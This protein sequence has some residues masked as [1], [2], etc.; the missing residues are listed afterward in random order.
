MISVN[1]HNA[2]N[3]RVHDAWYWTVL[4]YFCCITSAFILSYVMK[5]VTR[6][7]KTLDRLRA[8]FFSLWAILSLLQELEQIGQPVL[9]WRCPIIAILDV[10]AILIIIERGPTRLTQLGLRYGAKQTQVSHTR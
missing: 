9:V 7:W 5:N 10:L 8:S 2:L 4:R 6:Q 1:L 3:I